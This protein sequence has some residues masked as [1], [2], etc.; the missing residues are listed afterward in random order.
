VSAAEPSRP[1]R[2][3]YLGPYNSPHVEDLAVAMRERGHVVQA[4]GEIWSG[5]PGS[6][7]PEHG[8]PTSTMEFPSILWFRRLL[9]EFEPDVVHAHWMPFATLAMLAGARPLVAQAWGS[10]V[11]LAGRRHRFEL[12]VTL[13]RTAIAMTDSA[14]LIKRLERFGPKSLRTM[15]VN[16]GVDLDTF[17]PP[18]AAERAALKAGLGLE[19]GPVILS[20]R[21]LK[22]IYNPEVV[23]S[24]FSRL[25]ETFPDAQLV[26]KHAG[27]E[28]LL[29]PRWRDA[30][31]VKVV[32]YLDAAQMVALFRAADVTVS[33]P[34]SDSSPRSVW[35]AMAAGSAT[36]LSDLPWAHELIEDGRQSLLVQ[37]QDG[38]VASGIE[39]LLADASLRSSITREARALVERRRDRN[40]ELGRVEACYRDLASS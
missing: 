5:L 37:P 6:S 39:R 20:P 14:D 21:G 4:A 32:G 19:P 16:W 28:E 40:A 24:A 3:L 30:P 26:L 38:M 15:L 27:V 18:S 33:I 13:R 29:E 31:G 8:V 2:L 25:R 11:Y 22:D 17:T 9:R 23:V 36:V 12:R 35:E 7:L 1:L 10:D 34:K